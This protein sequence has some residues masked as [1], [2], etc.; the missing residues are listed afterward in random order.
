MYQK[1]F[2]LGLVIL[3]T[4]CSSPQSFECPAGEY[5]VKIIIKGSLGKYKG[6]YLKED[7]KHIIV[8]PAKNTHECA[9]HEIMH[10]CGWK[11]DK[12]NVKYC[13]NN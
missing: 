5:N 9:G 2:K 7:D 3:L 13:A 6:L 8:L 12:P 1:R 4:G 11:H 10:M